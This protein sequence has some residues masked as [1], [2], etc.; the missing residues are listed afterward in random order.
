MKTC[1][2]GREGAVR[3]RGSP[4]T[5]RAPSPSCSPVPTPETYVPKGG[6]QNPHTHSSKAPRSKDSRKGSTFRSWPE[7]KAWERKEGVSFNGQSQPRGPSAGLGCLPAPS[8]QGSAGRTRHPGA[9]AP[10]PQ[11]STPPCVLLRRRGLARTKLSSH[12]PGGGGGIFCE[13]GSRFSPECVVL[14]VTA[15]TQESLLGVC[16]HCLSVCPR[17]SGVGHPHRC[18]ITHV[19]Q[20]RL[21]RVRKVFPEDNSWH[22]NLSTS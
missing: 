20:M 21:L 16:T 7:E 19:A 15:T 17:V 22:L 11:R 14:A 10:A 4:S 13:T 2:R 3:P 6:H 9:P 18:G 5:R 8:A 12:C 1:K